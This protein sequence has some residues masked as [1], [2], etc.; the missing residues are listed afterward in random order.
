MIQLFLSYSACIF[1][2]SNYSTSDYTAIPPFLF[3]AQFLQLD[4]PSLST[5]DS[6]DFGN[7]YVGL[8][9]LIV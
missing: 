6:L 2:V 8:C 9:F 1:A 4:L 5:L 3:P 7:F